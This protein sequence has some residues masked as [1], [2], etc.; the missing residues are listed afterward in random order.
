MIIIIV[1][2]VVCQTPAFLNQL[3]YV[4]GVED[5]CG[6]PYYYY[7]HVSNIVVSANSAVN[8]VVYCVFR[9]QFRRRLREFCG[10]GSCAP[11]RTD[12]SLRES[13]AVGTLPR[14]PWPP[15]MTRASINE[16]HRCSARS[17][18][19]ANRAKEELPLRC[20]EAATDN[21]T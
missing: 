2:F 20:T 16:R 17:H 5:S 8:F 3:L 18:F 19:G 11:E 6:R 9:R 7:Y 21:V 13:T 4:I 15:R 12:D 1:I 14:E 10:R